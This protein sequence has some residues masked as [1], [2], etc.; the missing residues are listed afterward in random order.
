MPAPGDSEAT[1][2][3]RELYNRRNKFFVGRSVGELVEEIEDESEKARLQT[4]VIRLKSLYGGLSET[5][6]EGKRKGMET[7]SVWQ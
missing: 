2:A 6:Q 7:A 4:E 3:Q 5:Y 1:L